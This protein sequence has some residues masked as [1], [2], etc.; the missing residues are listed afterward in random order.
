MSAGLQLQISIYH[1]ETLTQKILPFLTQAEI[2]RKL[3][4]TALVAGRTGML[5]GWL[6][7]EDY[8][9]KPIT[10]VRRSMKLLSSP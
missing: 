9:T 10:A 2:M 8:Q 1:N 6:V 3:W 7:V 4:S 5:A